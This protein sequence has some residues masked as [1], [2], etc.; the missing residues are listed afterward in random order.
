MPFRP[1][2]WFWCSSPVRSPRRFARELAVRRG[3]SGCLLV[4][5]GW[6][7]AEEAR[8]ACRARIESRRPSRID[9]ERAELRA[10]VVEELN[11]LSNTQRQA[12]VLCDMEELTHEQ[13]AAQLGWPVGTVK[14]RLARGRERLKSRLIRR[15]LAPVAGA[16]RRG[17]RSAN[18]G[19]RRPRGSRRSERFS[20]PW[21][22]APG[23]RWPVRS[24]GSSLFWSGRSRRPCGFPS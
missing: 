10:I 1:R 20:S 23:F 11:R 18:R 12:V 5:V 8:T 7:P 9:L 21:E 14:S 19:S 15:G 4:R 16:D 3:V 22:P 24:R 2:S 13:A 6:G 17:R